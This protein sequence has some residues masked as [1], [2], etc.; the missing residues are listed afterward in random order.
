MNIVPYL[1]SF[2]V[3]FVVAFVV[4]AITTFLYSLIA[5]GTGLV[6]WESAFTFGLVF[7]IS[8]P[9]ITRFQGKK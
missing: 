1:R 3:I 6:N 5:H 8:L 7:G 9:L 4:S 2:L